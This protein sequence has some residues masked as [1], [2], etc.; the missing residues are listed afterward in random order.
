MKEQTQERI[1]LAG[2]RLLQKTTFEGR[3]LIRYRDRNMFSECGGSGW[4]TL[5]SYDTKAERDKALQA[6]LENDVWSVEI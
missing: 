1:M 5:A 6:T 3:F 4:R 2:F